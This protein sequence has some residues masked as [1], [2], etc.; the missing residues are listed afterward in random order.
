MDVEQLLSSQDYKK[1][2]DPYHLRFKCIFCGEQKYKLYIHK[3]KRVFICFKCGTAGRLN[4][5]THTTLD[6]YQEKVSNYQTPEVELQEESLTLPSEL[7]KK[8]GYEDGLPYR[9]LR[10]RQVTDLEIEKYQIGYCSNGHYMER[11]II[12]I[13][14]HGVPV[15]FVA[16]TYTSKEPKY[17]NVGRGRNKVLFK[18]FEG[19]VRSA[20]IVEGVFDAMRVGKVFP[21]IALLGKVLGDEQAKKISM[22][23]DRALVMLDQDANPETFKVACQLSHYLPTQA[24]FIDKKD[25]GGMEPSEITQLLRRKH[26]NL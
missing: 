2:S 1:T 13:F 4:G 24:V 5:Q 26:E 12:P 9:Y 17:L 22:A 21:A 25:P 3:R 10:K 19:R 7:I 6:D 14:E 23:T 11:L 20:T 15:Y 8:V 18:T 16:R